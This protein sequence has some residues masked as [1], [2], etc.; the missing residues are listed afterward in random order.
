MNRYT[1]YG[2]YRKEE[3]NSWGGFALWKS[4]E[5][6]VKDGEIRRIDGKFYELS[7]TIWPTRFWSEI[8][9]SQHCEHCFRGKK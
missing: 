9:T 5:F 6:F 4:N 7:F 3:G 8:Y 2:I 1:Q